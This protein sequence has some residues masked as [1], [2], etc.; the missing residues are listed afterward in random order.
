MKFVETWLGAGTGLL[1]TNFILS[2]DWYGRIGTDPHWTQF[3][4]KSDE[5]KA[6]DARESVGDA[7]RITTDNGSNRG[8]KRVAHCVCF[9]VYWTS[10]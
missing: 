8:G 3:L 5:A 10:T 6:R 4:D 1:L 2:V 9:V 7:S